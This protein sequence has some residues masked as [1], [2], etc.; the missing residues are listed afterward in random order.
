MIFMDEMIVG[1]LNISLCKSLIELFEKSDL[2]GYTQAD[3]ECM[4]SF[5]ECLNEIKILQ[6]QKYKTFIKSH[7]VISE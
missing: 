7:F 6:V 5:D 1:L 4:N 2:I 3:F